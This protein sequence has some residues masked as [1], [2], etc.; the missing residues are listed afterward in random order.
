M[1]LKIYWKKGTI[2]P[3]IT[4]RI[5]GNCKILIPIYRSTLVHGRSLI[6]YGKVFVDSENRPT[7][8]EIYNCTPMWKFTYEDNQTYTRVLPHKLA[9]AQK[10]IKKEQGSLFKITELKPGYQLWVE[11]LSKSTKIGSPN[12]MNPYLLVFEE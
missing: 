12:T 4:K 10:I 5:F 9:S 6:A 3:N 8:T 1:K 11:T 7:S 2:Y